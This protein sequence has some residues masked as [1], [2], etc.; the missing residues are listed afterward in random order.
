MKG[1]DLLEVAD[2]PKTF[3]L[4]GVNIQIEISAAQSL[5][6]LYFR[7]EEG[8]KECE[9]VKEKEKEKEVMVERNHIVGW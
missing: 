1:F 5:N 7:K 4:T 9:R 6:S 3:N 8:E 2:G